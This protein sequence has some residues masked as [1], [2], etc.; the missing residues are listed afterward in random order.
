MIAVLPTDNAGRTRLL[1]IGVPFRFF[2]AA[3]AFQ[4]AGW[5]ALAAAPHA[6]FAGGMGPGLAALHAFTLGALAITVIG[7]SLQLLPVATVQSAQA[8]GRAIA[9]WWTLV[10]GLVLQLSAMAVQAV[11]VALAGALLV[12]SALLGYAVLL[13]LHLAAARRQ[14]AMTWHAWGALACL[15]A[16]IASGPLL[17]IH[18]R[19]GGLEDPRGL[20]V[21]HLLLGGYG[22]FGLLATGFSY[23]LVPMFAVTRGPGERAQRALLAGMGVTL[24]AAAG[25]AIAGMPPAGLAM[26]ALA[27]LAVAAV[28]VVLLWRALAR[29]RSRQGPWSRLLLRVAWCALLASLALGAA[30]AAGLLPPRLGPLFVALLVPG[31]LLTF[32]LAMLLRILPFLAAVHARAR[33]RPMPALAGLVPP[34]FAWMLAGGHLVAVL[35]L[36]IGLAAADPMPVRFAGLAGA[37]T[38]AGLLAFQ[39]TVSIRARRQR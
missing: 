37:M 21:L 28:H 9:L 3:G 14:R 7:A 39:A 34:A 5:L 24:A 1:P 31:W 2:A 6:A 20:A 25:G 19:T 4:C 22:F 23:L 32:T 30:L 29:G 36:A 11:P 27:G 17:L 35:L 26:A 12:A 8:P 10:A 15:L 16:V 38:S 33:G 18:Q 13:G